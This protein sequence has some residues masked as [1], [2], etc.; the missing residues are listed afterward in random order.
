MSNP[1]I[2]LALGSGGARGFSH[3]GVIKVLKDYNIPIDYIAGSSMGALVGALYGAGQEIQDLYTLARTFKRKFFL[4]F[5]LPKM[6]FIQG[7]RIKEYLKLTT[8]NKRLEDF[9]IP[10]G[11]VTT[12]LYT[13]EKKVFFEGSAADAVRASISMPGIL[14]PERIGGQLFIDGGVVDRVPVSV[15]KDMGADIVIGVDCSRF[16]INTNIYSIYDVMLQ[17][18]EIMQN[19]MVSFAGI[20][21]NI[22]LAPDVVEYNSRSFTNTLEIISQGEKEAEKNIDHIFRII[23]SWKENEDEV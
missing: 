21:A 8:Y 7:N 12:N 15:V 1:K 9:H 22:M 3:L 13:G 23:K 18:I 16:T 5:T 20:D 17:S 11:I 19:K 6:G 4:D 2:G 14:V 10:V